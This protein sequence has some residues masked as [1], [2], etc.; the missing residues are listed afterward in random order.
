MEIEELGYLLLPKRPELRER[1]QNTETKKVFCINIY[2]IS[3]I[4]E[5]LPYFSEV[6]SF[7]S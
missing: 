1:P 2:F 5:D 4:V 6:R 7:T 3:W